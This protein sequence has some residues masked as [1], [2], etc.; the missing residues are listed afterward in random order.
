MFTA[1]I[2]RDFKNLCRAAAHPCDAA[3][4]G[5]RALSYPRLRLHWECNSENRLTSHWDRAVTRLLSSP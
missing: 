3:S 1:L 4:L 5:T 2:I